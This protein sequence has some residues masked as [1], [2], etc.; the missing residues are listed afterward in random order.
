MLIFDQLNKADKYLRALSWII[1]AGLLALLS[2]LWWVQIV[3]SRHYVEDQRNQS[4]R[5]VRVPAPR[6]KILDRNSVA[7]AENRAS[8]SISLYLED[9]SWRD[10]VQKEYKRSEEAARKSGVTPR[11]PKLVEKFLGF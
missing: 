1:A 11:K 7:L 10:A 6:G 3:R 5:T 8:Y 4:Y 2:G 9:R